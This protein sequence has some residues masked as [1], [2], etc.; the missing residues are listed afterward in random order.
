M[1]F[2][3]VDS[4]FSFG[5]GLPFAA[6]VHGFD[7]TDPTVVFAI[8]M[9][10]VLVFPLIFERAKIPGL[11][12]LI[13]AGI[14]LGPHASNL[15]PEE[16][17]V[18]SLG[19]AGLL[20][21]MLLVGLE[22]DMGRFRQ[23]RRF[24]V[25]FG[26]WTFLI[27]QV[28][29]TLGAHYLLG[30]SWPAAI[31]MASMF[32]SHTLVSYPIVQRLGLVKERVVTT[33]AGGTVI[34]DTLALTVLAV[35]AESVRSGG[36][37]GMFWVRQGFLFALYAF[38]IIWGAPK[39]GRWFFRHVGDVEGVPGFLF[40]L[41]FA[42]GCAVLAPLAGLEPIIGTFLAGLTLNLL[43]PEKSRLMIRL[44]F[45]GEGLFI[46]FFLI[47]VGL[48]VDVGLL[49][50]S[51]RAWVLMLYMVVA[52]YIT[53]FLAAYISGKILHFSKEE[54]GVL[55][56]LS[57]NQAAATLA[58]VIVGERLGIFSQ[59]VLNGTILMI[60]TTCL[61]GAWFTERWGRKLAL[62]VEDQPVDSSSA[63][64]RI[65][66]PVSESDQVEPLMSLAMMIRQSR[67]EE[68]LYPAMIV[69]ESED[70]DRAVAE[71]EK[72]MAAATMQAVEAEVE[73]HPVVRM[74]SNMVEEIMGSTRD[75][76]ISTIVLD[77]ELSFA[78][79]YEHVATRIVEQG[80][81]MVFRFM[82]TG[83]LNL[84]RR[85]LAAV[86]PL[87]ERQVGF[88]EAWE[89]LRRLTTQAGATIHLMAEG[90]TLKSME[91]RGYFN[92]GDPNVKTE[93]VTQWNRV[94]RNVKNRTRDYD[95][96]VFFL[97]RTG[98]LSW[99]PPHARLPQLMKRLLGER[100]CLVIYPPDMKWEKD[101]ATDGKGPVAQFQG[102]FPPERVFL[103][104]EES[105]VKKAV[106]RMVRT[107]FEESTAA[108]GR[109]LKDLEIMMREAALRITPEC[110]LLH[111]HKAFPPAPMVLLATSEQGFA[112]DTNPDGDS[113]PIHSIVVLLGIPD[114]S[115]EEHLRRLA[116][117]SSMLFVEGRISNI[118]RAVTYEEMITLL[119]KS[120]MSGEE[121]GDA[122]HGHGDKGDEETS[123]NHRRNGE[124]Q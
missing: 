40:V 92:P 85:F 15:I 60:L 99:K 79:E 83:P 91:R 86:P 42:F 21:L 112:D 105:T 41:S 43:I 108:R 20:Y 70:S 87:M 88:R 17:I 44:R 14:A 55:F 46:P 115:S 3:F 120:D 84:C 71:A 22:I 78:T 90:T 54:T 52:G 95:M 28:L 72:V 107:V 113:Q 82:R 117:I 80:R 18:Q 34:T 45:V 12:G 68:A 24:S 32:A 122:L 2:F 33:T 27:P 16:S 35:V 104:M 49:I 53:K 102:L 30:L 93:T 7:P 11:V 62:L 19:S 110:M 13:I 96:F 121:K 58:A 9:A 123:M 8:A 94:V 57:V 103:K 109:L 37:T 101:A 5:S 38:A 76:R 29:G 66:I 26:M 36:L 81:H 51:S 1:S 25:I 98:Q 124:E 73:V 61:G 10:V 59:D 106:D 23:E 65:M 97:A 39:L 118:C 50:G 119:S 56:G 67:S 64:E 89:S 48:R 4:V 116:V 31:L 47:S 77:D 114:E 74:S 111:S 100:P 6:K 63:P 75:L 69:A